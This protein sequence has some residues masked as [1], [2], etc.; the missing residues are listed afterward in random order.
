MHS[1]S[2]KLAPWLAGFNRQVAIR[3]ASGFTPTAAVAREALASITRSLVPAGPP[4]AHVADGTVRRAGVP[5]RVY[6][7]APGEARPVIVFFHGGGHMAGSVEVYDPICRRLA[8]ATHHCVVSVDYRLAPEHPYPA[9]LADADAAARGVWEVLDAQQLPYRHELTL[10]GD[11]AGG[12]LAAT[13]AA[14]AQFDASLHVDRQV[15]IYPSLDYTLGQ[16]SVD[17]NGSD[18]FL[19]KQRAAW[20]FE[21][22]FRRGEN[23]RTASPLFGDFTTRLPRTL[24]V[25]AGFDPLRDEGLSYLDQLAEVGVPAEHL[26]FDDMIHAFLNMEALVSD[27]CKETYAAIGRFV[28]A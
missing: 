19:D 6:H 28:N 10:A 15:L 3:V 7:T 5:V 26:H 18:Y 16:P 2:P 27:E 12:A 8:A 25:T 20:Y 22:Y 1:V 21:H 17:E 11:S 9:G 4:V 14:R 24:M 13:I 23:R